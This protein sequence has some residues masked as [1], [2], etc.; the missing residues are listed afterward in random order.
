M[1]DFLRHVPRVLGLGLVLGLVLVG[2]QHLFHLETR[3]MQ[4][5][6]LIA[7]VLVIL[8]ALG[9]NFL[10]VYPVRKRVQNQMRLLEEDRPQEALEDMQQMLE[11]MQRSNRPQLA[12]VCRMNMTAA[13]CDMKRYEEALEIL[14]SLSGEEFTGV[15][16][17]VYQ[18]NRCACC[19]YVGRTQEALTIFR[20]NQKLFESYRRHQVYGGNIAV[21]TMQ[22][23]L[24]L[25]QT[26]KTGQLL[27]F[28]RKRWPN[29][30]LQEDYGEIEK[31]LA[32]E[33]AERNEP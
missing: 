21:L 19:F 17:L 18:L 31:R 6:L 20:E 7:G 25:G 1:K 22:A 24:A 13:L 3:T 32:A 30:R 29:P 5:A 10:A 28:A 8:G 12:L 2:V 27:E 14:D 33:A 4:Y 23:Q 16:E 9:F 11:E 26:E 15:V